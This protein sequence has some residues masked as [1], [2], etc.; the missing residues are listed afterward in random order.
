MAGNQETGGEERQS[1]GASEACPE[2]HSQP[3]TFIGLIR[4]RNCRKYIGKCLRSLERQSYPHWKAL[5]C[6]DEPTDGSETLV[7]ETERVKLLVNPK[8]LG[9][10][11]NM[12]N[13][14]VQADKTFQPRGGDVGFVLDADDW[15]DKTALK[16]E[17]TR[18]LHQGVARPQDQNQPTIP[19]ER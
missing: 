9:L 11:R 19:E 10:G 15:L 12:H 16:H 3:L 2:T 8:R 13:V 5:V 17:E 1:A 4:G 18:Q 6:L 14:I 7:K